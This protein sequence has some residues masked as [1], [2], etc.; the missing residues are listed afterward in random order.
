[1]VISNFFYLNQTSVV[2]ASGAVSSFCS[3]WGAAAG[4]AAGAGVSSVSMATG[5]S[6]LATTGAS[7]CWTAAGVVSSAEY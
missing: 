2:A 7:G 6:S 3:C 4:A 5:S 1:M